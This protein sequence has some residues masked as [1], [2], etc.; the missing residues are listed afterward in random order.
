MKGGSAA[1]RPAEFRRKRGILVSR[2]GKGQ[3][4]FPRAGRVQ[5]EERPF[6][7]ADAGK[8]S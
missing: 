7:L 2:C 5:K 8:D 3:L 1:Y 6:L 4:G